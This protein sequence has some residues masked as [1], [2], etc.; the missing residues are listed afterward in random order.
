MFTAEWTLRISWWCYEAILSQVTADSSL[1]L[2]QTRRSQRSGRLLRQLGTA[3]EYTYRFGLAFPAGAVE[4]TTKSL[5]DP[6]NAYLP[7]GRP[8]FSP[9]N[10]GPLKVDLPPSFETVYSHYDY[11]V[12]RY[13]IG[14]HI[15]REGSLNQD[16]SEQKILKF[17]PSPKTTACSADP[18]MRNGSLISNFS[19]GGASLEILSKHASKIERRSFF[20]KMFSSNSFKWP[21]EAVVEFKQS[22]LVQYPYGATS[23]VL[24]QSDNLADILSIRL[25]TPFSEGV[26]K[27]LFTGNH[28]P[29]WQNVVGAL[30]VK[31]LVV[32]LERM[33]TYQGTNEKHR[34]GKI[35]VGSSSPRHRIK[36]SEFDRVEQHVNPELFDLVSPES[37]HLVNFGVAYMAKLPDKFLQFRLHTEQRSFVAPNILCDMALKFELLV[38]STLDPTKTVKLRCEAPILLVA[39]RDELG[40]SSREENIPSLIGADIYEPSLPPESVNHLNDAPPSYNQVLQEE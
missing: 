5:I 17:S 13:N 34:F 4:A 16:I 9:R 33:I 30:V 31:K 14:V 7:Y 2:T 27:P 25:Y 3:C 1:G 39:P 28:V 20:D 38:T 37:R 32:T 10:G 35:D 21:L 24:H 15:S 6:R 29:Y 40:G 22:N 36:L 11:A 12:I 8:R 26:L 18:L 19:R 23:R